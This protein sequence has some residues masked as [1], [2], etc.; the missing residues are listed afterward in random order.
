MVQV[1]A[2]ISQCRNRGLFQHWEI[3]FRHHINAETFASIVAGK[4]IDEA[5]GAVMSRTAA[6]HFRAAL[7]EH[8]AWENADDTEIDGEIRHLIEVIAT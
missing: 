1:V 3:F 6:N 7:R 8:C 2:A 5:R 4:K